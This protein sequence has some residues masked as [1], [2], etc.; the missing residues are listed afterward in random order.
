VYSSTDATPTIGEPGVTQV[1]IGTGT[2]SFS[3]TITGLA[4]GTTYHV[5]AYATNT[6]GT[7]Y[8]TVSSFAA[9][10]NAALEGGLATNEEN[11]GIN[12]GSSSQTIATGG[13]ACRTIALLSPW[14]AQPVA[15]TVNA[16]VWV[17]NTVPY[18]AGRPF[19][20]RS[21]EITPT[22]NASTATARVT[23]YFTQADFDQYNSVPNGADLPMEPTDAAGNIA[24]IRVFKFGG[25][26]AD[27]SGMPGSF[28]QAGSL[29]IDPDDNDIVWN[30]SRSR[31]E[32]SFNTTGFSGFFLA[33]NDLLLLPITLAA[34][35]GSSSPAG[36]LL[37]WRTSTEV[38]A[39]A[40]EVQRSAD[41]RAFASIASIPA[42][43]Q[44]ANYRY[45]DASA[46]G[47]LYYRLRLVD[48]DG[49]AAY[50]QV[51]QLSSGAAITGLQLFP[52][53]ARQQVQLRTALRQGTVTIY[54][55]QGVLLRQLPWQQ[56]Q[57]I[58]VQSLPAGRYQLQLSNGSQ[59]LQ[60]PLLKQ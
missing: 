11:A 8:G 60:V 20:P 6:A 46:S 26:S 10:C 24:N 22:N 31:W 3:Q 19:V 23:L 21:Y 57:L 56:G 38:N 35:E 32:V 55:A 5:A 47:T 51:L 1:A 48:K 15:G 36:N 28:T 40:I 41:G 13:T 18:H 2:G 52:N 16:K 43:G 37:T 25:T 17:R 45:T 59:R 42:K 58:E 54:N 9:A 33:N 4:L 39:K 27:G 30:A 34:F 53:P 44:P 49:T 12:M 7:A 14:G 29:I 50:S